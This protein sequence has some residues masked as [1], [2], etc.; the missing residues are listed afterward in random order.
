VTQRQFLV[1]IVS[2]LAVLFPCVLAAYLEVRW[3]VHRWRT[4]AAVPRPGFWPRPFAARPRLWDWA[5]HSTFALGLVCAA[6]AFFVEPVA[7]EANLVELRSDRVRPETGR[8]R[9]VQLSDL[10]CEGKVL[11]EKRVVEVVN[12][13]KP[14][15][16]V[17]TGD[18][19]NGPEG[20]PV[21]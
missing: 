2:V 1:E 11:N 21:F 18:Y 8:I 20:L 10:H 12:Y 3:V 4:R 7:L 6:D 16:I 17:M 13:L 5:L 19:A 14:D 15:L 9:V